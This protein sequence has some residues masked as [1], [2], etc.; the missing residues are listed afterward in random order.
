MGLSFPKH[1]YFIASELVYR[2]GFKSKLLKWAFEPISKIKG[3]TDALAV[4]KALRKIRHGK[5]ICAVQKI[6]VR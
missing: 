1:M 6:F 3:A 2:A 4:A 5:N